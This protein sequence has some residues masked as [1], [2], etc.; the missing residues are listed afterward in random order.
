MSGW[1]SKKIQPSYSEDI[2]AWF[3]RDS[4]LN[5]DLT[6]CKSNADL[7]YL[8][9]LETWRLLSFGALEAWKPCSSKGFEGLDELKSTKPVDPASLELID[10]LSP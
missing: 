7:G 5:E 3:I 1:R 9:Q 8:E 4:H 10:A 2:N 6:P